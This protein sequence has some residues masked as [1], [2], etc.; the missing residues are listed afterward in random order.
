MTLSCLH[1]LL[2]QFHNIIFDF[3]RIG[4]RRI[5]IVHFPVFGNEELREIPLDI[6]KKKAL[7]FLRQILE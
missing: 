4:L 1:L 6:G 7:L 2:K 3:T 5:A